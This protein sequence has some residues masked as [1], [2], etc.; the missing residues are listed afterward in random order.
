MNNIEKLLDKCYGCE[1][2]LNVCPKKAIS[3]VSNKDGFL[4]PSIDNATCVECGLCYKHCPQVLSSSCTL[5]EK[6]FYGFSGWKDAITCASGGIVSMISSEF[7][8]ENGFVCGCAFDDEFVAR[9]DL[10]NTIE[11]INKFKTSKYV[12]SSIGD[13]YDRIDKELK[14]GS[15]VLF[16]GTPC[17][18]SGIKAF[19]NNDDNLFTIDIVCHG[20]PSPLLFKYYKEYLERKYKSNLTSFNF[21]Y[22][23]D[24]LW[25]HFFKYSFANKKEIIIEREYDKYGFDYMKRINYRESCYSCKYSNI[26][27]RPGDLTV[28]D[29]W[30]LPRSNERFSSKGVSSIVVN[31]LK[32]K[33]LLKHVS[34]K[35]LFQV[36][37][38]D[39]LRNQDALNGSSVRTMERDN[40]YEHFNPRF[41]DNKKTP[42]RTIN[43]RIRSLLPKWIK[44]LI[45]KMLKMN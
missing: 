14:N 29:F 9:H 13:C 27:N 44:R 18:V 34:A 43:V 39:V 32:G 31:T 28:G 38:E 33:E 35:E 45:K 5:K 8:K 42:K 40:Y 11:G 41:F 30:G 22:K 21:R 2:C 36:T 25:G 24:G 7:V 37:K 10:V 1:C 26:E 23:K 15:K 16:I 17:Q 3:F 19:L 4:Y 6:E 20:V 12:Q